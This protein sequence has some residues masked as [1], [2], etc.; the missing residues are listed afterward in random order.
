MQG[1]KRFLGL[2]AVRLQAHLLF[3]IHTIDTKKHHVGTAEAAIQRVQRPLDGAVFLEARSP[4]FPVGMDTFNDIAPGPYAGDAHAWDT[5]RAQLPGR[6]FLCVA[7]RANR[8]CLADTLAAPA[9]RTG[10]RPAL[11]AL[12]TLVGEA[13]G[14][15]DWA[16]P[17]VR[18]RTVANC[19]SSAWIRSSRS[20]RSFIAPRDECLFPVTSTIL[21]NLQDRESLNRING[22][23]VHSD[24]PI[25]LDRTITDPMAPRPPPGARSTQ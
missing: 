5:R 15:E 25:S 1:D 8:R 24:P 17:A 13:D 18:S 23:R 2:V 12:S 16:V 4:S 20:S 21:Q 7:R 11:I 22:L 9:T 14:F 6:A 10:R 3:G 19:R